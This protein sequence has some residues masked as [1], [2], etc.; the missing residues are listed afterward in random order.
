VALYAACTGSVLRI[1]PRALAQRDRRCESQRYQ[2][3]PIIAAR[4]G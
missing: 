3:V 1:A 2:L 4:R